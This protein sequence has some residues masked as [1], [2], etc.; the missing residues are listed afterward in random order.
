MLFCSTP[1]PFLLLLIG[2]LQCHQSFAISWNKAIRNVWKLPHTAH[3][4]FLGPLNG[5][6]HIH[7]QIV[8]CFIK[9]Y[10][11]LV[12]SDNTM[13]SF[14][15]RISMSNRMSYLRSNILYIKWKYDVDITTSNI[16]QCIKCVY[17]YYYP[18]LGGL[19]ISFY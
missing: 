14:I 10:N 4:C 17:Y 7:D 12:S 11:Q 6:L 8:I 5:Q 2:H 16:Q 13:V 15:A 3:T 19:N 18:A 1:L 9:F